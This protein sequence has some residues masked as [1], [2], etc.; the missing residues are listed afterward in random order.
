MGTAIHT[1]VVMDI[2]M[3]VVMVIHMMV[4]AAVTVIHTMHRHR[5][6]RARRCRH[7]R[8]SLLCLK[9]HQSL[10][11][12]STAPLAPVVCNNHSSNNNNE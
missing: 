9:L 12:N 1:M 4:T 5:Q 11:R 3:T 8:Q 10:V 6:L 2:R 7:R